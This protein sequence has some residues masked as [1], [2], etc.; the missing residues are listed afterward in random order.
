[1]N[2]TTAPLAIGIDLGGT[3]IKGGLVASDGTIIEKD[4]VA[5]EASGGPE[6]VLRRIADMI[7]RFQSE[8]NERPLLGAGVGAPGI[9]SHSRGVVIAPPN[10]DGWKNVPIVEHIHAATGLRIVLENDANN[11]AWAEFV[12]GAGRG[13][14]HMVMLTIGTGIGG[15]VII[16]GRLYRGAFENAGELGHTIVQYDGRPCNCGQRGCL[17]AHASAANTAARVTERILAGEPSAL[18]AVLD[19]GDVIDTQLIAQA[20]SDGDALSLSVWTETCRYLAIACINIQHAFNPERIVLAGGMSEAGELLRG[21]VLEAC[22]ELASPTLGPPPEIKTAVL[23]NDA[24]FVGAALS[25][26]AAI[27]TFTPQAH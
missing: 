18:K 10:L 17:E 4:S 14:K 12:C 20:A 6:H 8:V 3:A 21:K 2:D 1:M 9:L 24:G 7:S 27:P 16:D 25:V 23:G 22:A 15:G 13:T 5:T 26:F 11:A 19:R